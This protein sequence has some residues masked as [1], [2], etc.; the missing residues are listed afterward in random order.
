MMQT[1]HLLLGM[2]T[3]TLEQPGISLRATIA[4]AA[5]LPVLVVCIL[6]FGIQGAAAALVL[7]ETVWVLVAWVSLRRRHFDLR[8]DVRGIAKLVLAGALA[9]AAGWACQNAAAVQPWWVVTAAMALTFGL[10]VALFR[11]AS[12]A[13]IAQVRRLL[14]ARRPPATTPT[15]PS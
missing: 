4:A 6:G 9:G 8:L 3:L 13:E 5:T 11:P 12:A 10:A 2:I 15:D 7:G 14:S 1:G